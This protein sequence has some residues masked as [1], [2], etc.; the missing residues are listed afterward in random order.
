MYLFI[1]SQVDAHNIVPCWEASDQ[2][3]EAAYLMRG[4]LQRHV[5]RYMME[6]PPVI[7]HPHPM[8]TAVSAFFPFSYTT[9]PLSPESSKS[10]KNIN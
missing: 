1:L 3:E 5:Q 4:K 7:Q 8:Q 9:Y 2:A 10:K 6:F